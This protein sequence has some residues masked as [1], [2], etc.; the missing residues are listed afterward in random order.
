MRRFAR[1]GTICII[2]KNVKN[3]HGGVILLVKLQASANTPPHFLNCTNGTK[4]RKVSHITW[5]FSVGQQN[6]WS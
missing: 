2:L 4:S 6:Y 5:S 3:I 1:F